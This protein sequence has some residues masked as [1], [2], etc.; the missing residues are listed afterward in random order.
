MAEDKEQNLG[1]LSVDAGVSTYSMT[2]NNGTAASDIDTV[3]VSNG[4]STKEFQYDAGGG[5]GKFTRS[6]TSVVI[7]EDL[8][9]YTGV[10]GR[11]ITASLTLNQAF[12]RDERGFPMSEGR[13]MV[14]KTVVHHKGATDYDVKVVN[15]EPFSPD[16][17]ISFESNEPKSGTHEAWVNGKAE[18]TEIVLESD[19][20][21]PV[22]WSAIEQHGTYNSE[23]RR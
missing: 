13:T 21:G 17:T 23:L 2:L 1:S 12:A 16:R 15:S 22:I 10:G 8:T 14:R 11:R 19:T 3:I 5:A 9:G 7:S 20:G 4:T 6:G 18:S